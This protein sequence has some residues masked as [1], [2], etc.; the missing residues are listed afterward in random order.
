MAASPHFKFV[1]DLAAAFNKGEISLPS[2]PDIVVRIRNTLEKEDV[3]I[4][5]VSQVVNSDPVL[6]SRLLL[7][8]NSSAYNSSGNRIDTVE[9]A[10]SRLGFDL[11]KNTA[12]SLAVR[13]MFLAEQHK[14][15]APALR[16]VWQ[17]SMQLAAMCSAVVDGRR[18]FKEE[19]AF[20]CGLLHYV[21]KLYIFTQARN[22]PEFVNDPKGFKVV[23]KTWFPKVGSCIVESW[24][25]PKDICQT[26]DTEEYITEYSSKAPTLVD[27][28]VVSL[29]LLKH[30]SRAN[31]A[32]VDPETAESDF[33]VEEVPAMSRL[34][35]HEN[36]LPQLC[37]GFEEKLTL[38]RE[39]LTG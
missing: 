22:Y 11:V 31:R 25:F 21:G 28:I 30:I 35:L 17:Q 26:L 15:L 38:L 9:A 23:L 20:M 29:M 8:A 39:A 13:Q 18:A 2:F 14:D 19:T 34:G 37:T 10:I 33:V 4:D 5:Q 16:K 32:G 1:T 36:E 6:V 3:Y 12:V 7:F 24:G 27:V